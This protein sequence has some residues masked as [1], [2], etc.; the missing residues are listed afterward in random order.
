MHIWASKWLKLFEGIKD[1]PLYRRQFLLELI[2][3][4][5]FVQLELTHTCCRFSGSHDSPWTV[6]DEEDV[7]EIRDEEEELINILE[8]E[9]ID[10]DSCG[11]DLEAVWRAE[12]EK[13]TEFYDRDGDLLVLP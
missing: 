10:V 11:L 5:K 13:L 2:R 1:E 8:E 4:S 7:D 12:T 3:I 6:L 9:M